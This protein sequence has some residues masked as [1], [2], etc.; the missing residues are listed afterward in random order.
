[1][2]IPGYDAWK[3]REPDWGTEPYL[4]RK[5]YQCDCEECEAE[6]IWWEEAENGW[7]AA[8]NLQ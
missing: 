6:L 7:R 2:S 8:G 3:T 4:C 5:P 1:M